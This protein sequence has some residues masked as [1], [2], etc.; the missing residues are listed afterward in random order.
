MR[1][2]LRDGGL[3]LHHQVEVAE[4]ELAGGVEILVADVAAAAHEEPPIRD[5][6]LVVHAVVKPV[7]R[8][9]EV[10]GGAQRAPAPDAKGIV[11]ADFDH[12]VLG[13]RRQRTFVAAHI[14]VIEQEPDAHAAVG[15]AQHL[16][17]EEHAGRILVPGVILQVERGGGG[18]GAQGA[19]GKGR[20]VVADEG[21]ARGARRVEDRDRVPS[22]APTGAF[23]PTISDRSLRQSMRP[24]PL[25]PSLNPCFR[26]LKR[27]SRTSRSRKHHRRKTGARCGAA[28]RGLGCGGG[29]RAPERGGAEG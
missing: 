15:G 26:V 10:H 22:A 23:A 13:Q 14:E 24:I 19:Y 4:V 21:D 8:Q 9:Q 25:A 2:A 29:C 7:A 27:R 5:P 17:G 11:Q 28:A 3:A 18:A 16:A 20:A 12:R 1:V 6:R